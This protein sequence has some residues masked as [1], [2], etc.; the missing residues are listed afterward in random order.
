MVPQYGHFASVSSNSAPQDGHM[1]FL[2]K[3]APLFA[4]AYNYKSF[5]LILVPQYQ[6]A[7]FSR[8][9]V[10]FLYFRQSV[11]LLEF[12][13]IRSGADQHDFRKLSGLK[14]FKPRC[15]LSRTD[16]A[17]DH[18]LL[19]LRVVLQHF[20]FLSEHSDLPLPVV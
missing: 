18:R 6:D 8:E 15:L 14:I 10:F 11:K 16:G 20:S 13:Q 19:M 12:L 3:P 2:F 17:P 9:S 1:I 7:V 4:D 5:L